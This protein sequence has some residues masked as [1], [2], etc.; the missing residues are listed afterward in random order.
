MLNEYFASQTVIND[1]NKQLPPLDPAQHALDLIT[2]TE[3]DVNNV[4]T[5]L[6][7]T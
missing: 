4:L 2:L 7:V 1:N 6:D 5:N 3:Q